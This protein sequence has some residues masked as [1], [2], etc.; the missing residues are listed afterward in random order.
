MASQN[1]WMRNPLTIEKIVGLMNKKLKENKI[2]M[3]KKIE[4]DNKFQN[5]GEIKKV[6][7][8][9]RMIITDNKLENILTQF[10]KNKVSKILNRPTISKEIIKGEFD[11]NSNKHYFEEE[12]PMFNIKKGV[13]SWMKEQIQNE[14]KTQMK[15]KVKRNMDQ[16]QYDSVMESNETKVSS[17]LI[18]QLNIPPSEIEENELRNNRDEIKK[19][20]ELTGGKKTKRHKRRKKPII[21]SKRNKTRHKK[22]NKTRHKINRRKRTNVIKKNGGKKRKRK[23]MI[24]CKKN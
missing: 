12:F 10:I 2:I 14:L 6:L 1:P 22:R 20:L 24:G 7:E 23:I 9:E 13:D 5:L 17:G 4:E 21:N 19:R 8:K 18:K 11:W 16:L 15:T 3:E